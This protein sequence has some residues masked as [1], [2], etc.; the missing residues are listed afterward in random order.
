M[1]AEYIYIDT[2]YSECPSQ[3]WNDCISVIFDVL[4]NLQFNVRNAQSISCNLFH[5]E[6]ISGFCHSLEN[7]PKPTS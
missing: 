3:F 2:L 1:Q 6:Q 7:F 5:C 4:K